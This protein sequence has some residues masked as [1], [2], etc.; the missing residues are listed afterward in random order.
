MSRLAWLP[1]GGAL[2]VPWLFIWQGLDFTDQGYLLTGYRC[3][4]R[5]PEVTEDSGH[6]W[7]TNLVGA[8]WDALFGGLGVLAL[9][10]LFALCLSLG[11]LLAFRT[12]R[13]LTS[14]EPAAFSV[15]AA[16]VFL[17]D[18][19]ETWF[20]YNTLS[21][22]LLVV[23]SVCLIQGIVQRRPRWLF[24]AGV[25]IGVAPF[26]RFPNLLNAAL[27]S[28]ILLAAWFEPERR[29]SLVR[30]VG[31]ALLGVAVGAGALLALIAVRGD[32]HLYGDGVRSLFA[33]SMEN[34][35]YSGEDLMESFAA[36]Q[37]KA[38]A[39]GLGV[40]VFGVGLAQAM[41]R[42][43][44]KLRWLLVVAACA[45]GIFGLAREGE[46]WRWV[47]PGTSYFVLAALAL[48]AGKPSAALRVAAWVTLIGVIVAPLGS[49]N[50]IKNAHMGL[51]LALPVLLCALWTWRPKALLDQAPL[52]ALIAAVVLCAE[53]AY[54][55]HSYTYRDAQRGGLTT[56]IDHPQLR[57]QYT[58][59]A[60]AKSVRQVLAALEQRV[61]PGDYILAYEGTPLLQY[62]TKTRPY[63]NRPWLMGWE[64]ADVVQRLAREA[65]RRT[66][67]LPV[68]VVTVGS[69][70]DPGWPE[71]KRRLE[72]RQSQRG[73]RKVLTGFLQT[74]QYA[75]TWRNNFFEI[76]EPPRE[77]D[78]A[79]C[80]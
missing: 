29:K 37:L 38:V 9:R 51:W 25:A 35:G 50:G 36:D 74:N 58:T 24:A 22:L 70:R 60:R 41:Q 48:G 31:F 1:L 30:D 65:P 57:G 7:L 63:L 6:M 59:P 19:R 43:P 5:Y 17:A 80:R 3:F 68:V 54:R 39:W 12:V 4:F 11:L 62:L 40:C 33:P 67:C 23:A 34:A 20:S 79:R 8:S 16:S 78:K 72:Q 2:L 77:R 18:R 15:L 52:L 69:T 73:V 66:G 47:V 28:A 71:R 49:N 64:R 61:D 10:G 53:G 46:P 55:A 32:F 44:R 76:Y 45:L 26:A 75:R 42:V 21:S 14:A 13:A 27:P 56:G